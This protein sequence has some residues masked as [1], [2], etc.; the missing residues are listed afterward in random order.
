MSQE[1][2]GFEEVRKVFR[3]ETAEYL[4]EL[5][6]LTME[7]E[8]SPKDSEDKIARMFRRAHSIKG[9]ASTLGFG[10][11]QR[12]S[13]AMEEVLG[14][15][16]SGHL[17]WSRTVA[18]GLLEGIDGV[19]ALLRNAE[20]PFDAIAK[21]LLSI[22]RQGETSES[23][24][25]TRRSRR[26]APV[27]PQ[28]V[29]EDP[30]S[31]T[32]PLSQRG[33][34]TSPL[35]PATRLEPAS[36]AGDES[37]RVDRAR[38]DRLINQAAEMTLLRARARERLSLAR[39]S[40]EMADSELAEL[41]ELSRELP[42][43]RRAD[44]ERVVTQHRRLDRTLRQLS[45]DLGGD[46]FQLDLA[47]EA[48]S[49]SIREVRTV[50]FATV[51]PL[52]QRA[53][54]TAALSLGR[55]ATFFSEGGDTHVDKKL[56]DDLIDPL[57]HLLRNAVDHGIE[58]LSER[59]AAGKPDKGQIRMRAF[60]Q[61]GLLHFVVEDD[62]R[63]IDIEAVRSHAQALGTVSDATRLSGNDVLRLLFLPGFSTRAVAGDISG[64]GVGLDVVASQ[65]RSLRGQVSVDARL[66]QGARFEIAIPLTFATQRLLAVRSGDWTL[67]FP[68]QAVEKV[69]QI[70]PSALSRL[71]GK[72]VAKTDLGTLACAHLESIVSPGVE[73]KTNGKRSALIVKTGADRA[74]ITIDE[75]VAEEELVVKS[76]PDP[77]RRS[78]ALSGAAIRG[79]GSIVVVLDAAGLRNV[80]LEGSTAT[81][82][83]TA[84]QPRRTTRC[85][86][87]VDDSITSRMLQT[88]A[89]ESG[90]FEVV[91]AQQGREALDRLL[92]E[93]E[94]FCA[95]VADVEMPVMDG[96]TLCKEVRRHPAISQIPFIMLTSITDPKQRE[97]G[98]EAGANA[99]LTKQ[100]Y[101]RQ[102]LLDLLEKL[103]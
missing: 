24:K 76:L 102:V 29:E 14:V 103:S 73:P 45:R 65:V 95:V 15:L 18:D 71:E 40:V 85:V 82:I 36:E 69:V 88:S 84:P 21:K 41:R 59:R 17:K 80:L 1:P 35:E 11:I 19:G 57:V 72:F 10:E 20:I 25:G 8:Q 87:V 101:D 2:D 4:R 61:G 79:D 77:L 26:S 27:P 39:E 13:Y 54:R 81:P 51:L 38:L 23:G 6:A 12:L 44:L 66:G 75:L 86:L 30:L 48:V 56:L 50:A 34:E 7:L 90:G 53:C 60:Q 96:V 33:E 64:R 91:T 97:A 92:T 83:R 42:A 43:Q 47:A 16:R 68:T 89:I 78:P 9:A 93:P 100:T 3:E 37:L 67:A 28:P 5:T 49:Q 52:L 46:A 32:P 22:P 94:R 98:I 70:E 58:P 99:Y 55:E 31:L 62:G 63:G 74:A